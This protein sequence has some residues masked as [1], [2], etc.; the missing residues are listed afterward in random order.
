MDVSGARELGRGVHV[1]GMTDK[2]ATLTDRGDWRSRLSLT[3][4]SEKE[5]EKTRRK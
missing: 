5:R 4:V 2:G 1:G 3:R